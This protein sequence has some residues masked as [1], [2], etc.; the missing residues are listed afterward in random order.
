L[1]TEGQLL[2]FAPFYFKNGINAKPKFFLILRNV[3]NFSV[4][5]S[6]PTKVDN[7]PSLINGQ[8]GCIDIPDRQFNCYIFAAGKPVCENGFSFNLNTHIY[9]DQID[10]YM[11]ESLTVSNTIQHGKD[12]HIIGMLTETELKNLKDCIVNSSSVKQKIRKMLK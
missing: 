12:Y 2:Y 5:A 4:V 7:A 8:H 9:G 6:L 11:I 1:F 10:T 3:D